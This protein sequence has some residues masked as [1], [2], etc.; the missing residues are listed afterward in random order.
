MLAVFDAPRPLDLG[1]LR[2]DPA[3]SAA[4][5][6]TLPDGVVLLLPLAQGQ[7]LEPRRE[8]DTWVLEIE[9]ET[10]RRPGQ[11]RRPIM[12]EA[13]P[14]PPARL[15]I[16]VE[17]AGRVLA[18]EDPETGAPLLIGTLVASGQAHAAA[19]RLPEFE[20]LPTRQGAVILARSDRVALRALAG[21][22]TLTLP[23]GSLRMAA[24]GGLDLTAEA[25]RL[26][27]LL[28]LPAR[29]LAALTDRLR[30]QQGAIG[31]AL[32]LARGG[33]RR[34]VTETLLA[35]GMPHEA[36]AMAGLALQEDPR[37]RG[38]PRL[39]L[40]HGAAALLAG[41][42]A[43][44]ATLEDARIPP[45]DEVLLWRGL[46]AA[47]RGDAGLAASG[48]APGMALLF[49]Y[50]EALRQRLLPL[51]V[52][53]LAESDAVPA[54]RRLL[55]AL[56]EV[57][58]FAY[59]RARLAED[60]GE[61]ADAM[62][63]Y[64]ALAAS[65]DR[66]ARARAMRRLAELRL[67]AGEID[68]A[69]AADALDRAIFAWRDDTDELAL[70][71]RIAALRRATGA[72]RVAFDLLRE[73]AVYFPAHAARLR[74][75]IAA[76]F[77]EAIL[78]EPP[79]AAIT[80]FELHRDLLPPGAEGAETLAQLAERL[81][82]MELPERAIA[83][84]Q[85]AADRASTREGRARHGARIAA[86]R[87][88]ERDAAAAIAALDATAL[89]EL[90]PPLST[91]RALL[92]A[93]AMAATRERSGAEALLATLG[94]EGRVTL[95]E[96]RAEAGDWAGAAATLG[97]H[98]TEAL[99]AGDVALTPANRR[100]IARLAAFH[101]LA[102][103]AA[104]LPALASRVAGRMGEGAVADIFALLVSDPLRGIADVRRLGRELDLFRALPGRLSAQGLF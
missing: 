68:Q 24:P 31:A 57:P 88:M 17:G 85:E 44:A 61:T 30:A 103:E 34:D 3:F 7:V 18:M 53:A 35:L 36:Q 67:A 89:P 80:L 5:T 28:D 81:V 97:E 101:A 58:A 102:G 13:E 29:D 69:G 4:T 84:L 71:L 65:N 100:D 87:L 72:P 66:P 104:Q 1:T 75:E 6:W 92:R 64:M 60:E 37:T 12:A 77:A 59:A 70:R 10:A 41:R 38:D 51:A 54:T 49:S 74:P 27:R 79:V 95:A 55:S 73:A 48:I 16:T 23:G 46:L 8:G 40:A 9:A 15:V 99:T 11:R 20:V 78:V 32:P 86:L 14:G 47:A 22:F 45:S 33:L 93:R 50:P 2:D 43:D 91:E 42:L 82:A 52:L 76:T 98:L 83:L 26:T 25:A 19:W 62:R 96:I 94:A 63:Q 56:P 21:Q 39:L 90:P